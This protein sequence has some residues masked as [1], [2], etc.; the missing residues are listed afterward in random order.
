MITAKNTAGRRKSS[1]PEDVVTRLFEASL[2]KRVV[3]MRY[4]SANSGRE[5]EYVV[6]PY[7]LVYAQNGLYLQ[8]FVPAYAE[9]RTFLVTRIRRLSVQEN[10]FTPVAELA[11]GDPFGKS[12]GAY[13]GP[14]CKVQLRFAP[15]VAAFIKERTWHES[16]EL[17]DRPDGSVVLKMQ[18][19]DDYALRQW[20]LG[21]GRSVRVLA[22]LSLVEWVAEEL[23]EAREQYVSGEFPRF[24]DRDLQPV[25]PSLFGTITG[26]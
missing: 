12:L 3:A 20:I 6:N 4:H 2:G 19:S 21:F 25:L 13:S 16:Q 10:T 8:A 22:P 9:L 15:H 17:R 5:K 23:E 24:V 26:S 11:A 14:T 7:R 1:G 18:V